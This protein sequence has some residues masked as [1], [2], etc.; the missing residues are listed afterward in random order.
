MPPY[1]RYLSTRLGPYQ[2]S[3]TLPGT[4][5]EQKRHLVTMSQGGRGE[6]HSLNYCRRI[7]KIRRKM[8]FAFLQTWAGRLLSINWS[9]MFNKACNPT[10]LQT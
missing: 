2:Q 7:L 3:A 1:L 5:N 8:R 4:N 9:W 10:N 6:R